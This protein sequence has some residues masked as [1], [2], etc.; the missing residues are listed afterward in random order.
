MSSLTPG[1]DGL[2][3]ARHHPE[4]RLSGLG[5]DQQ[6]TQGLD[7]GVRRAGS[8]ADATMNA[9][10][11]LFLGPMLLLSVLFFAAPL[12][13]LIAYSFAGDGGPSLENYARFLG[14]PFNFRVLVNTV[15]LGFET[16]PERRC[17]VSRSRCSTGTAARACA[18]VIIFLTLLPMLTSN[19]VRTFAW[20]VILGRARADQRTPCRALGFGGPRDQPDVH[21]ARPRHGHDADRPAAARPAHLRR[22][23]PSADRPR[24]MRREVPAPGPGAYS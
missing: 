10:G 20:I 6:A 18:S 23:V 14:D 17:S 1:I 12:A 19:V 24:R 8:A 5:A 15:R 7:P 11:L 3:H 22:A 16:V 13:L 4:P 2:C 21:R 9:G